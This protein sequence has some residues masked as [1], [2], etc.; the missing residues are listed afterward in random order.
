MRSGLI[1]QE[2]RFLLMVYFRNNLT[3]VKDI[4]KM[5]ESDLKRLLSWRYPKKV[6]LKSEFLV[7]R[8]VCIQQCFFKT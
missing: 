5:F 4:L 7:E 1:A 3:I 2:C 6:L 8:V